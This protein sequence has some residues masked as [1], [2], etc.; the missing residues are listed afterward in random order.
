MEGA[1]K[2]RKADNPNLP[3]YDMGDLDDGTKA[4]A[5]SGSVNSN[6]FGFD[7]KGSQTKRLSQKGGIEEVEEHGE[8]YDNSGMFAPE[9]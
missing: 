9:K 6:E 7:A 4:K 3:L 2:P 1:A 5:K 8:L